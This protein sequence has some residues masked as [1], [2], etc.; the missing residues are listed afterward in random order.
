MS[1]RDHIETTEVK[2]L[3]HV[4]GTTFAV[5]LVALTDGEHEIESTRYCK[6]SFAIGYQSHA[7]KL[8]IDLGVRNPGIVRTCAT[9]GSAINTYGESVSTVGYCGD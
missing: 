7:S 9:I 1:T 6:N 8:E 4:L 5:I 2:E 3:N